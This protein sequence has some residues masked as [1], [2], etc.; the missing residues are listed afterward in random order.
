M[1]TESPSAKEFTTA[2]EAQRSSLFVELAMARSEQCLRWH[3]SLMH[4]DDSIGSSIVSFS[5]RVEELAARELLFIFRPS[6]DR[7]NELEEEWMGLLDDI[8]RNLIDAAFDL[9]WDDIDMQFKNISLSGW[10]H[11]G[12]W[13]RQLRTL[14]ASLELCDSFIA[15]GDIDAAHAERERVFA[16]LRGTANTMINDSGLKTLAHS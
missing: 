3:S 1:D 16:M 15:A 7:N 10:A 2:T 9:K 14:K 13:E 5:R 12:M 4:F 11:R 8:L 6:V